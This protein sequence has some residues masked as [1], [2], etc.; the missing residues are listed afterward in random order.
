MSDLGIVALLIGVFAGAGAI[1]FFVARWI[2]FRLHPVPPPGRA[3][4][5]LTRAGLIFSFVI[6]LVLLGLFSA[7]YTWPASPVTALAGSGLGRFILGMAMA[8]VATAAGNY[9]QRR[10]VPLFD[11]R[12]R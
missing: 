10:G 3:G 5:R 1:L 11:R 9:L 4:A 7:P 8:G 2:Y 12:N 6:V